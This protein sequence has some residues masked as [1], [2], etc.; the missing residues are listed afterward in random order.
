MRSTLE[1][2][3]DD[4]RKPGGAGRL[5]AK[6]SELWALV[7]AMEATRER[8]GLRRGIDGEGGGSWT[9]VDQDGLQRIT[10][11]IILL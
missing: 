8:N 2:L 3:E 9:V 1:A 5:K 6:L 7:G 4:I 11:V 10:Q